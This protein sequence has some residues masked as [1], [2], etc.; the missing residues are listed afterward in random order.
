[1]LAV[2]GADVATAIGAVVVPGVPV[3]NVATN[4]AGVVAATGS[5]EATGA[6]TGANVLS[7]TG[8]PEGNS[9]GIELTNGHNRGT[10]G[11][12]CSSLWKTR[13]KSKE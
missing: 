3:G 9:L 12:S 6:A 7:R 8:T 2:T 1:M 11:G 5:K 4:G 13:Q 10:T